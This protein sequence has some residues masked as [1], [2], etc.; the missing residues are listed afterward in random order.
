MAGSGASIKSF[1]KSRWTT[2]FSVAVLIVALVIGSYLRLFPVFNAEKWGYGPMLQELDPYSEYWIAKHLLSHG[3]SYFS[4]LTP[5][6]PVTHIFWYPWGRDFTTTEPP[7]LS[8]FSVVTYYIAHAFNPHLTLYVW[9][10]YLPILFYIIALLGIYFTARE[11]WGDVAAALAVITAALIFISRHQAGFT[12]KYAIGLAFIFPAIYF[13][14][15]AWRRGEFFSAAFAGIFLALTALSWAGFNLLLGAI[16][17]Q[18]ILMPLIKRIS[19]E[20]ILRLFIEYAPLA[21]AIIG[22]PFYRGPHYMYASVGAVIPASIVMLMIAYGIQRMARSKEV[23][24]SMPLFRR[25]RLIYGL[26]IILI[27][28][29]GAAALATGTVAVRGKAAMA[30]GLRVHGISTTVQEYVSPSASSMIRAEGAALVASL[31]MIVY[32]LYRIIFKKDVT[33]LFILMLLLTALYSTLH[34]SYFM[35]YMNYVVS[36]I[37]VSLVGVLMG[38]VL[39]AKFRREWFIDV[40]ALVVIVIYSISIIAQGVTMWAPIYESQSPMILNAGLGI[41]TD[42]PSWLYTLQWLRTHTPQNSVVVAWW[43]YGY[44]LSVVG[45]RASVADGATINGSQI[46]LLAK[47][48]T[49]PEE[50]AFKIFV[51]KFHIRP[52]RLYVT[53]YEVYAVDQ[54]RGYVYIGPIVAG[55]TLI[56]ADAAKGIAAIYKI[57]GRKPP[58]YA[59]RFR[60]FPMAPYAMIMYLP[61]WTNKTLQNALLYKILLNTAYVVWGPQGYRVAFLYANPEHPPILPKPHMKVFEPA[62]ISVSRITANLYVVISVYKVKGVV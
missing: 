31:I 8:M 34:L 59:Y 39:S 42:A 43:D 45:Q 56:G 36:L 49:D 37:S 18:A 11:I 9:M 15:R 62:F 46:R 19:G 20:D 51:N 22:S 25:H 21:A 53:V 57:A 28:V 32:M 60:P 12:V 14:V 40:I 23:V 7:L 10:V 54:R 24:I 6:N 52:D 58:V 17:I 30:L 41:S 5:A 35:P 55:T 4:Q 48:L 44:W 13:H 33:Y 29:G 27:F 3:L 50:E 61:D 2:I 26:L 16:A 38:R 47:A 1:L